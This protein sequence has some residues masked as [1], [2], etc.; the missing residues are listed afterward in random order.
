MLSRKA[1]RP[2]A[3]LP[4]PD[5][6]AFKARHPIAV[7]AGP[8]VLVYKDPLPIAV[9]KDPNVL[10]R[11]A[12]WPI[13]VLL[14]PVA[15][16]LKFVVAPIEIFVETFPP[17]VLTNKPLMVPFEP[18]VEIEPVTPREPV[19]K[20]EPVYGNVVSGAYEALKAFVAKDAVVAKL[21][22]TAFKT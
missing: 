1:A 2:I 5:V 17:P 16:E 20:A 21:E 22:L 11:K 3:V 9:L 12:H 8:I 4:P 18:D 13:A 6:L 10:L 14:V 19:I 7:L 15:E